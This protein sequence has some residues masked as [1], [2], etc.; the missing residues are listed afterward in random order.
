MFIDNQFLLLNKDTPILQ[1]ES[2]Y[3]M[4]GEVIL[5]ETKYFEENKPIGFENIQDW[6]EHRRAPKHRKHIARLLHECGCDNLEGYIRVSYALNLND[7]FW[8]KPV[9]SNKCWNE[10]SL[11]RNPFNELISHIAFEGGLYGEQFS[12][13]SPEFTTEGA[14]AKCW[15]REEDNINLVKGGSTGARNAGKEPH[16]EF[17]AAQIANIICKN[18]VGYKMATYRNKIVSKC[19]LFTSEK[20]GFIPVYKL[21]RSHPQSDDLIKFYDSIGCLDDFRRMVVL[22]ALIIN[23]DRHLGNH[24]VLID[25]D[26]Q[27][28]LRMAP[29]FDHN[30]ALLPYAEEEEFEN[31]SEYLKMKGPRIGADFN[32]AANAML[33][34]EIR[35]DLIN[36]KGFKFQKDGKYDLPDDRLKHLEELIEK[37]IEGILHSK[38]LYI[39]RNDII[40]KDPGHPLQDNIKESKEIDKT[41]K[42]TMKKKTK[43]YR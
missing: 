5:E 15:I 29:V 4:L 32:L 6:L 36:L 42:E 11:Y 16:S 25:N 43:T 13:T 33:T 3:G 9:D 22:D 34:P 35:A 38:S 20:E 28:I 27:K 21:I 17:Y 10:V 23:D 19:Q 41:K 26:T 12:T 24:G 30:Q 37:Q 8:V 40:S 14:F 2:K 7:T 39:H 31:I 18:N 1:F